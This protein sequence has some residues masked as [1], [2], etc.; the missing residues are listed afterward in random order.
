M[1]M[2]AGCGHSI[3]YPA[4]A[5]NDHVENFSLSFLGSF[6]AISTIFLSMSSVIL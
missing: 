3:M 2:S 5:R 1:I 4:I 6:D